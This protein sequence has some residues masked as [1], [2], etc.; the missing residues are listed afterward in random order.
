MQKCEDCGR[1]TSNVFHRAETGKVQCDRC[2]LETLARLRASKYVFIPH[3]L[4]VR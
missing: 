2:Y 4:R 1:Y 3:H